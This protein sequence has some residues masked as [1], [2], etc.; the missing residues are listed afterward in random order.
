MKKSKETKLKEIVI[1]SIILDKFSK[2]CRYY[3]KQKKLT[4]IKEGKEM[5]KQG[6]LV[7]SFGTSHKDT[8]EKTIDV[9]ERKIDK[10]FPECAVYRAYTSKMIIKKLKG[11]GE[12]IFNVSEALDQMRA[13]GIT[14]VFVQPTHII[15]GVENDFM[16]EDVKAKEAIFNR[17]EIGSPL[18]SDVEDYKALAEIIME[19]EA[20]ETDEMLVLM[21]HGSSHYANAAY[22]A[23]AYVFKDLGYENVVLGTVEGYPTFE[24]MKKQ[25]DASDKKKVKLL[26]LMIVAG[27]HAKND[28]AGDDEDSWKNIL[29]ADGYEVRY[30]LQGL[31]ELT[32]IQ[33]LFIEHLKAVI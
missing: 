15:N 29:E 19:N 9:I 17:V 26:P 31:G 1:V 5:I 25:L 28:M 14:D 4:Y 3:N 22:P 21:G 30:K 16:I 10:A 23:L 13:D 20:P 6:I 18:L 8:R 11:L 2:N 12:S 7:V 32:K 24:E 33:E 27:D